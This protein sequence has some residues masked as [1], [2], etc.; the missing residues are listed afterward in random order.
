MQRSW[1]TRKHDPKRY[2]SAVRI[3][4]GSVGK[5]TDTGQ[6]IRQTEFNPLT[7]CCYMGTA[8]NHPL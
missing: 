5:C 8:T 6:T 4:L 3:V 7:P 1:A 2:V